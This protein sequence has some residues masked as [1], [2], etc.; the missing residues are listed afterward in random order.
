MYI[1]GAEGDDALVA[2]EGFGSENSKVERVVREIVVEGL[3][4]VSIL[5][6]GRGLLSI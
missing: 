6:K 2:A 3:G 5:S 1:W 4:G